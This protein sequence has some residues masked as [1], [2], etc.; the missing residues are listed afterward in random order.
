MGDEFWM[1]SKDS[2]KDLKVFQLM[3]VV[4]KLIVKSPLVTKKY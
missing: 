2:I 4:S 1:K 3:V